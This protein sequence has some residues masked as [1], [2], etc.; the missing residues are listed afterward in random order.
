MSI[1]NDMFDELAALQT[2]LEKIKQAIEVF[3]DPASVPESLKAEQFS[4]EQQITKLR[5]SLSSTV[6]DLASNADPALAKRPQAFVI[7]PFKNPYNEYYKDI[8]KPAIQDIGYDCVRSDEIYSP[9]AFLQTIWQQ[10][11]LADVMIAE[12]TD[13]NPNVLYEL[14]LAHS[15]SKKVIMITQDINFIPSDLRH[16]NCIIY[17]TTGVS[18]AD[19][20]R[21]GLQRM[22][23]FQAKDKIDLIVL[24]PKASV[25]NTL[26]YDKLTRD[27]EFLQD[28]T[29]KLEK[30]I[31]NYTAHVRD[32][33]ARLAATNLPRVT[34]FN[35]GS[36]S[37]RTV[38]AD[39]SGI[40]IFNEHLPN[41]EIDIEYIEVE[42][43][44]FLFGV[45]ASAREI[46]TDTFYITRFAITNGQF[47][48]F[49]NV[50]GNRTEEGYHWIDI[51]GRS[52]SDQCRIL[53]NEQGVY[54]CE[55]GY[56]DYPVTYVNFFGASA[57]CSWVG[58]QL[59]TVEEW[60]KAV[61]GTDG[62]DYPW[63]NSPPTP[64]LTNVEETGWPRDVGPIEVYRKIEGASPFGVVQ[65]I[66]NVWHWTST[67]YPDRDVQA[68]RGG[69]FF[70]FRLGKRSVY[71]FLVQPNGPDF[72]QGFMVVK[73]FL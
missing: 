26:F 7:M 14:G 38:R 18:W 29:S 61:R 52:S 57:F 44:G 27:R 64:L 42:R 9:G 3:G 13:M 21:G 17:D 16:I 1:P 65:G 60:E 51:Q 30:Q 2:Q 10:I 11:V 70:D 55:D 28:R 59:P 49:L 43:G 39:D 58:G 35:P 12:M 63:G 32:L 31:Q 23:L 47:C 15:I 20:L 8:L 19:K 24:H 36:A 45:G 40:Q 72:S 6:G 66:G 69:S 46:E 25:D 37:I 5:E 48:Q 53:R 67:Y 4:A 22:V 54:A 50:V 33:R 56:L 71:R 41:C 62:R 34:T 68:V 73:R